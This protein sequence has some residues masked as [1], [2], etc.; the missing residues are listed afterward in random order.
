MNF[1]SDEFNDAY[2]ETEIDLRQIDPTI[3]SIDKFINSYKT[4][5]ISNL[6]NLQVECR[7]ANIENFIPNR[8]VDL[9]GAVDN[10][11][12]KLF[13]LSE[14][15]LLEDG[16]SQTDKV[17]FDN[18]ITLYTDNIKV[19]DIQ[20][21]STAYTNGL[22]NKNYANRYK[23]KELYIQAYYTN[24]MKLKIR[25]TKTSLVNLSAKILRST[26]WFWGNKDYIVL[27]VSNPNVLGIRNK[28]DSPVKITIKPR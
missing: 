27:D 18:I 6:G 1:F 7:Q 25:F 3:Q 11:N 12:N 26:R 13:S 22:P 28:S 23:I 20:T 15:K 4:I 16:Y 24:D 17:N 5:E 8:N 9:Y 14:V 19:N 10:C 21:F 2:Y